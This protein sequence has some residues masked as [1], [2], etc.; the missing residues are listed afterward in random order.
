[1]N[2]STKKVIFFVFLF[3]AIMSA[4][5]DDTDI[6]NS[7]P[8]LEQLGI[9]PNILFLLDTS[10]SM[11]WSLTTTSA[12]PPGEDSRLTIMKDTLLQF[13]DDPAL[14]QRV[15]IGLGRFND[16][17]GSIIYPISDIDVANNSNYVELREQ[18][19]DPDPANPETPP[20]GL[21][22]VA[23]GYTPG[24][25]A[26]YEGMRYFMGWDVNYGLTRPEVTEGTGNEQDYRLSH[27]ATMVGEVHAKDSNCSYVVPGDYTSG[28]D[29]PQDINCIDESY[30]EAV[31]NTPIKY[32]TPIKDQCQP[33]HIVLLTDGILNRGVTDLDPLKSL[34]GLSGQCDNETSVGDEYGKACGTDI[35]SFMNNIPVYDENGNMLNATAVNQVLAEGNLGITT[36]TIGFA[37]NDQYLA[38]LANSGGGSY[39]RANTSSELIRVFQD[40]FND[41]LDQNATYTAPSATVNQVNRLNHRDNIFFALFHPEPTKRW[42]GNIKKFKLVSEL[43]PT[44][45]NYD[46]ACSGIVGKNVITGRNCSSAVDPADGSFLASSRDFW[47]AGGCPLVDDPNDTNNPPAQICE[48]QVE[49]GGAA[50]QIP[51]AGRN[52]YSWFNAGADLT[53]AGNAISAATVTDTMLG[54]AAGTEQEYIDW[55]NGI[56][57]FDWDGDSDIT[58]VRQQLADP[59]HSRPFVVTYSVDPADPTQDKLVMFFGTNEGYMHAVDAQ[60]GEELWAFM[61]PEMIPNVKEWATNGNSQH[62]YGVDGAPTVWVSENPSGTMGT[63]EAGEH[64][65]LYFGMRRGGSSYYALDVTNPNSP[66]LMWRIDPTTT[67]FGELAQSWSKPVRGRIFDSASNP[68]D[69]LFFTAGYDDRQD[70]D[71]NTIAIT[72]DTKGRAVYMVDAVSGQLLWRDQYN[73]STNT[74]MQYSMPGNIT[75]IDPGRTGYASQLYLTDVG[76]QVWRYDINNGQTLG[77]SYTSNNGFLTR[78]LIAQ[79]AT[80]GSAYNAPDARRIYQGVD[81]GILRENNRDFLAVTVS[82]G[83]R[84]K[85]LETRVNYNIY[86]LKIPSPYGPIGTFAPIRHQNPNDLFDATSNIIGEGTDTQIQ[87]ARTT[88]QNSRGWFI[89]LENSGEKAISTPL[90]FEGDA[91]FVTYEPTA[92]LVNCQLQ[93][94]TTRAYRVRLSDGVPSRNVNGGNW[95]KDDRITD[96]GS[97]SLIDQPVAIFTEHG[98]GTVFVGTEALESESDRVSRTFWYNEE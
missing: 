31:L 28:L 58:E 67:G 9:K 89:Q 45:P 90:I 73:S 38:T 87:A 55:A 50:S 18:V 32:T 13:I 20:L 2:R 61:P 56:D 14:R 65:Y 91:I 27:H 42:P 98:G 63:I 4:R 68:R 85:P 93:S 72:P 3:A 37:N 12:P 11:N 6:Y 7:G 92:Q 23:S 15:R 51:T 54:V 10:G 34:I 39:N 24:I 71:N 33:N 66:E 94:G 75:V 5:A 76:G 83:W 19:G 41:V 26:L 81:V 80:P 8:M 84:A 52:I 22:M 57:T 29:D 62:V 47:S 74:D 40:I 16:T 59:L 46:P 17:S 95:T 82:T 44:D 43:D 53:L 70:D 30:D 78:T 60:T 97:G 86:M 64:V 69:V 77:S 49:E 96:L 35:A 21:G 88:L 79:L 1:M 36:H 48:F 25:P